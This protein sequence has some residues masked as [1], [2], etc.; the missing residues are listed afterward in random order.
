MT[1]SPVHVEVTSP[2]RFERAMVGVR[3]LLGIALG[4][5]GITGGWVV[6]LLY[7]ALPLIA[8][9][10]IS[11]GVARF[12]DDV[13]PVVTGALSWLLQ[14][15]AF[16]LILT[17]RFPSIDAPSIHLELPV[18]GRP[19]VRSALVRLVTSLPSGVVLMFLWFGSGIVWLLVAVGVLLGASPP[20]GLLAYQRGVLRW[21]ARLV[22][23]HASL[24]DDYPPFSFTTGLDD[25]A[26]TLATSE[27]T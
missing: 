26:L 27:A 18:S 8:A 10:A 13:A 17:D 4:W 3:I 24:V 11:S 22:A 19:T 6:G 21:Q 15:S 16:M 12:R 7:F 9:I 1:T 25:H 23:Y 14:L 2:F 5:I 20:D